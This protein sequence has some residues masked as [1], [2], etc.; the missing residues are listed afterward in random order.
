MIKWFEYFEVKVLVM[1][2]SVFAFCVQMF[3]IYSGWQAETLSRQDF[4]L[5]LFLLKIEIFQY[6]LNI[7]LLPISDYLILL[8]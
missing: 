3:Q 1:S 8:H 7:A 2:F 6:L 5:D 4:M